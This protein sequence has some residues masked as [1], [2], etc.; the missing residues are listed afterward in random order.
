MGPNFCAPALHSL[1][2]RA[3]VPSIP[4]SRAHHGGNQAVADAPALAGHW[5]PGRAAQNETG[6][7]RTESSIGQLPA[8]FVVWCQQRPLLLRPGRTDTSPASS[9]CSTYASSFIAYTYMACGAM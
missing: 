4:H 3:H 1:R 2:A 7:P 8:W 5:E 6:V 9:A